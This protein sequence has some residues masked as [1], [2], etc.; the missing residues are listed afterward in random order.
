MPLLIFDVNHLRMPSQLRFMVY[1]V[2]LMGSRRT[3]GGPEVP[4]FQEGLRL[5]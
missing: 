2:S 3:E 4:L 1:A 5:L